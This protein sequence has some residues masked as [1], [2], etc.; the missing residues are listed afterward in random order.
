MSYIY[1][2]AYRVLSFLTIRCTPLSPTKRVSHQPLIPPTTKSVSKMVPA[3]DKVREALEQMIRQTR[4]ALGPSAANC[5]DEEILELSHAA[6][7]LLSPI[8]DADLD[9]MSD[10]E[11][12]AASSTIADDDMTLVDGDAG[13]V[14]FADDSTLADEPYDEDTLDAAETL[15]M[16]ANQN[17]VRP[18][19]DAD[20]VAAAEA[21]VMLANSDPVAPAPRSIS[22]SV[23]SQSSS[24]AFSSEYS[25]AETSSSSDSASSAPAHQNPYVAR[26]HDILTNPN[27]ANPLTDNQCNAILR[28]LRA[29]GHISWFDERSQ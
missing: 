12:V 10:D 13:E 15:L 11:T 6:N 14:D 9:A 3:P 25:D 5:T 19:H 21:L 27:I 7:I 16:L 8:Q 17:S 4:I 28:Y 20:M 22:A 2:C 26:F 23:V 24:I 1:A 18:S 29:E